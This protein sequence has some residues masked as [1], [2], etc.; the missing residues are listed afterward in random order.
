MQNLSNYV[1]AK[2]LKKRLNTFSEAMAIGQ[3]VELLIDNGLPRS[4]A[5][6]ETRL[7]LKLGKTTVRVHNEDFRKL[8]GY[9]KDKGLMLMQ[10]NRIMHKKI[11]ENAEFPNNHPKTK[12]ALEK[13]C[14]YIEN[15]LNRLEQI[16]RDIE[17]KYAK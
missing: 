10:Y 12:R 16:F 1:S 3:F 8:H 15:N 14:S 4:V 13:A 2:G 17:K 5:I 6:E 9:R 7:W 11:T